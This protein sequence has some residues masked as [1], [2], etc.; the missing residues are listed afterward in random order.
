M[1]LFFPVFSPEA[2]KCCSYSPLAGIVTL[3]LSPP[4]EPRAL[5]ARSRPPSLS[6][7]LPSCTDTLLMR[8]PR[9]LEEEGA[10]EEAAFGYR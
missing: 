2:S 3:S 9:Q 4:L 8:A 10:R 5:S 6:R 1:Q 7:A